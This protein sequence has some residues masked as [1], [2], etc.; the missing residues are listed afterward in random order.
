M[1]ENRFPCTSHIREKLIATREAGRAH[2]ADSQDRDKRNR[3]SDHPSQRHPKHR[4]LVVV[5]FMS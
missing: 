1:L 3:E 4:N 2:G 5:L